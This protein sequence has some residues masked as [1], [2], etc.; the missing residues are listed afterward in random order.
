MEFPTS[1]RLSVPQP[2]AIDL[3]KPVGSLAE[4]SVLPA[5]LSVD[6][7]RKAAETAME[8]REK[9]AIIRALLAN[10][11]ASA[12]ALSLATQIAAQSQTAQA[13]YSTA[14]ETIGPAVLPV[15][16]TQT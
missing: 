14:R 16:K 2:T 4:N 5:P 7:A 11:P 3:Q 10:P 13:G 15:N 1:T 9:T 6:E 12:E 8:P